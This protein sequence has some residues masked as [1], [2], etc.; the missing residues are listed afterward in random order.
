MLR[1]LF[2]AAIALL[3]AP[4]DAQGTIPGCH[5]APRDCT[6][7]PA[8]CRH[9]TPAACKSCV[10][11]ECTSAARKCEVGGGCNVCG[12]CCKD[13]LTNS[14]ADCDA[15]VKGGCALQCHSKAE[16][17]ST[18]CIKTCWTDVFKSPCLVD[19]FTSRKGV[20]LL[21]GV[22]LPFAGRLLWD[23]VCS[24]I[25]RYLFPHLKRF[26]CQRFCCCCPKCCGGSGCDDNGARDRPLLTPNTGGYTMSELVFSEVD[27]SWASALHVNG[28]SPYGAAATAAARLVLWHWLQ[29]TLYYAVFWSYWG[30]LD[31]WQRGFG[32]AVAVREAL[33]ALTVLVVLCRNPAFLLVDVGAS[34]RDKGAANWEDVPIAGYGFLA[35]YVLAPEKLAAIAAVGKG[36]GRQGQMS[37]NKG[38]WKLLIL[39]EIALDLC[40]GA[41]LVAG[42]ASPAGLVPALAVGYGVTALGGLCFIVVFVHHCCHCCRA[43]M[44]GSIGLHGSPESRIRDPVFA[45]DLSHFSDM[46]SVQYRQPAYST[47]YPS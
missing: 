3:P 31:K 25:R 36:K 29:P 34:V 35:M 12:A 41:A 19:C 1:I 44:V 6:V 9:Y 13:Y 46:H 10:K 21:L 32:T 7:C 17:C 4:A 27:S 11:E 23:Y 20:L 30:E 28:Q 42:V 38:L 16:K 47:H 26:V 18:A 5:A 40:G 2:G 43:P 22:L 24:S 8:C 37:S 15:C 45:K 39:G 14:T 33:Y